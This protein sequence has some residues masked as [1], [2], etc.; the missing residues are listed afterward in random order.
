MPSQPKQCPRAASHR[1]EAAR[2][3]V[4]TPRV[5]PNALNIPLIVMRYIFLTLDVN[6]IS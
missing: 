3:R 1:L 4:Q 5:P 2:A 6:Q